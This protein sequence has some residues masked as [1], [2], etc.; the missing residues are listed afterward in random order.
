MST[1]SNIIKFQLFSTLKQASQ[2]PCGSNSDGLSIGHNRTGNF[3]KENVPDRNSNDAKNE[4]STS[5]IDSSQPVAC[6]AQKRKSRSKSLAYD[7]N[8]RI[9]RLTLA[10]SSSNGYRQQNDEILSP[11]RRS[12]R[13]SVPVKRYN[14]GVVA[15]SVCNRK[16]SQDISI[17]HY[18]GDISCSFECFK[19]GNK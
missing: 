10:G 11:L 14:F 8:V 19:K 9:N 16:F 7:R 4:A 2:Q 5:K 18:G 12:S 13:I 15:C 6:V 3:Q 17:E 1:D